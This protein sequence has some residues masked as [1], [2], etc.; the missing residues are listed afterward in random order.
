M[1]KEEAEYVTLARISRPWGNKGE[2]AADNLAGGL[3]HFVPGT[4]LEVLLPNRTALELE[5]ARAREHKGRV[6]LRFAGFATI[7]DAERL[8][9]AEVRCEKS[10]LEPLPDGEYYLDDL[11]GCSMVD[12]STGRVLGSVEDVYEP[13]GGVLLFSVVD[14]SRKEM[15]VPF[16]AEIC[17]DVDLDGKRILVQLPEGMEDLK[18]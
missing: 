5:L 16:A 1:K 3:R 7:S 14:D 17:Q 2:V 8:R 12:A 10:D 18:A 13:P 4:R 11:I 15:L 6:V 9:G